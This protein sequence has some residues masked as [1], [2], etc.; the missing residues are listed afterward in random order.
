MTDQEKGENRHIAII[1]II[2]NISFITAAL[3]AIIS[4][5]EKKNTNVTIKVKNVFGTALSL[6]DLL[7]L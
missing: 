5:L 3:D 6:P 2:I 7:S 4:A 1:T